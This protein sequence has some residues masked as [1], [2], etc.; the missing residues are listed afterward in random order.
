M[1]HLCGS[2]EAASL[3]PVRR[4]V[5]HRGAAPTRVLPAN[6]PGRDRRKQHRSPPR[7]VP[8]AT[9]VN[10]A[11][12]ER[13]ARCVTHA[14]D[15]ARAKVRKSRGRRGPR[16]RGGD[17]RS[18]AVDTTSRVHNQRSTDQRCALIKKFSLE[19]RPRRLTPRS[20]CDAR[21]RGSH[22]TSSRWCVPFVRSPRDARVRVADAPARAPS[23]S[24]PSA[25]PRN[26]RVLGSRA[27]GREHG[28]CFGR[29][30]GPA[31][32]RS[33]RLGERRSAR[34]R[35]VASCT[36]DRRRRDASDGLSPTRTRGGLPHPDRV[37]LGSGAL[38]PQE[39][40][41]SL[42]SP[43]HR[44]PHQQPSQKTFKI[45][46]KLGKKQKQNRPLPQWIR[47]RTG[48]TIRCAPPQIPPRPPPQAPWGKIVDFL[49]FPTRP[50]PSISR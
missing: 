38:Q 49:G 16:R 20:L 24:R 5:P 39:M 19:N 46:Q 3:R 41:S 15:D 7:A 9:A 23:Q 18:S 12:L 13:C 1:S 26:L 44:P 50:S 37:F 4:E 43:P 21:S 47:M 45:K 42:T 36:R 32:G 33:A 22:G 29:V 28:V 48:N 10:D 27:R 2:A 14:R 25:E 40:K 30:G 11:A 6:S 8:L 35:T 31:G 34:S 17:L